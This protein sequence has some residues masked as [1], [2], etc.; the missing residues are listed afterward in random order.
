MLFASS[1]DQHDSIGYNLVNELNSIF[2]QLIKQYQVPIYQSVEKQIKL[3]SSTIVAIEAA[4]EVSLKGSRQIF[5]YESLSSG[6]NESAVIGFFLSTKNSSSKDVVFGYIDA[7]D[8]FAYLDTAIIQVNINGSLH[9]TIFQALKRHGYF[10]NVVQFGDEKVKSLAE[11]ENIKAQQLAVK[12]AYKVIHEKEIKYD[13][14]YDTTNAVS[15]EL[16]KKMV[17]S[18]PNGLIAKLTI[19]EKIFK[20]A[21]GIRGNKILSICIGGHDYAKELAVDSLINRPHLINFKSLE[22]IV[23]EKKFTFA[24]VWVNK[25]KL[26][27]HLEQYVFECL[28][29]YSWNRL[30]E[31]LKYSN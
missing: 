3:N 18:S 19:T 2:D 22:E 29:R 4:E 1:A 27:S 8:V 23:S 17:G 31:A 12:V 15:V 13:I 14:L 20:D 9:T 24:N 28:N 11:S 25:I 6:K 26:P 16:W 30:S 5:I 7:A 10:F 21:N